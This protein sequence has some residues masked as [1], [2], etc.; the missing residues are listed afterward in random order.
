MASS[1]MTIRLDLEDK[2]LIASYAKTFGQS[3]SDFVREAALERIEDELDLKA[4]DDAKKE[5][6]K[7]PVSYSAAEIAE[8]YL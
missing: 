7:N 6:E 2:E 4:W 3:V 1:T 5:Y 8:K